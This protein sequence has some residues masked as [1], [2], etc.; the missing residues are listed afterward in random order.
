MSAE[1]TLTGAENVIWDLSVMYQGVDDPKIDADWEEVGT[2]IDQ[3]VSAYRGRIAGM[4]G[5]QIA[6]A[7]RDL[8]AIYDLGST[9]MTYAQL[10][11]TTASTDPKWGG[12]LQK[13][14]ERYSQF[15][16]K[17]VFFQ[18]EL[19]SLDDEAASRL[20]ADPELGTYRYQVQTA[21]A[22]KPYEL[23]EPEEKIL[24]EKATTGVNAWERFFDQLMG[25]MNLDFDGVP[26]PMPR[27]L[28]RM[29]DP[30]REVRRKAADAITAGLRSKTMEL[31]YIFN[32]LLA[33]KASDDRLRGY[34]SWITSRN[35]ANKAPDAVV[36]ALI[37]TVIGSY[38]LVARHSRLKKKLLGLDELTDY[39]RYAPLNLAS[40][41]RFYTWEEARSICL[42]AF[43]SFSPR[44]AMIASYFFE[45]NWIHAPVMAGKRG[46]AYASYGTKSTHPWVFVNFTG[47]ASDVKT[48][49]HEL[50]HGVHMY[51]AGQSQTLFSMYT[52][53]TTAEMASTFAEIVVFSDLMSKE[54]NKEARLAM[55]VEKIDQN[56]ATIYRQ[57]SMNRFED[58]IHHARRR[59]GELT[60]E[61]F[62]AYWMETQKA[63]FQGSVN[64][65]EDY[66]LWWSYIPHF[67]HT[68]GYVYAYA[69]GELLVMALYSLYQR[70]GSDFV[71]R[72]EQ[73]LA[74]GDSDY[75]HILLERVG[76]NLN[77]P[78][79]W[80]EGV[81]VLQH[82]IEQEEALAQELFP[83]R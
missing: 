70:Q 25:A 26:T 39:D 63:M 29:T 51:L 69:F 17:L 77:D 35:I 34:P 73:L 74:A 16:Q 57:V 43:E 80:A 41:D 38:D 64:L 68:P 61:Q 62:S 20:L 49:A 44:M 2:M 45:K 52:P 3:F 81:K 4:N 58:A 12:F 75:P 56:I 30:S 6:Q 18:L 23:S 50:G 5:A 1:R 79:F 24:I 15:A 53:L 27:V 7:Y 40:S 28:A 32:T 54:T 10:N 19:N 33:E 65:R 37:S 48:L 42:T 46:G 76:V 8:E 71:P 9:A 22:S 59:D 47:T 67:L 21:R 36:E 78:G 66:G 83:T 14:Q 72:Y 31:T 82:Y 55:L 11:F 60:T 13:M